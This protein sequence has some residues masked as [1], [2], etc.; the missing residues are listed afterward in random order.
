[1]RGGNYCTFTRRL[2]TDHMTILRSMAHDTNMP[3]S[4]TG[5][6]SV[7]SSECR[8]TWKRGRGR[9]EEGKEGGVQGWVGG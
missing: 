8:E 9:E 2:N 6:K 1:M 5:M 4:L 7:I 3:K